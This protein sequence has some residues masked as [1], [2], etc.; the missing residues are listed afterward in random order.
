[1]ALEKWTKRCDAEQD[2]CGDRPWWDFPINP[3]ASPQ[4]T[5]MQY[6]LSPEEKRKLAARKKRPFGFSS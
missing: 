6:E 2:C 4:A 1:M 3:T 5:L